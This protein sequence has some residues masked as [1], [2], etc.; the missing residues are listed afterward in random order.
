[1]HGLKEDKAEMIK[2]RDP[3]SEFG[4]LFL[5]N[6]FIFMSETWREKFDQDILN[7]GD[8]FQEFP[9]IAVKDF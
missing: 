7:W 9:K 6:S 4:K 2:N 8:N 1:M 3:Y 5:Q